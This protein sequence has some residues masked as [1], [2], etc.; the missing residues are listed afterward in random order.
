MAT[1]TRIRLVDDLDNTEADETVM[2][3]LDGVRYEIDLSSA[4]AA[5][6]R[7]AVAGY[8]AA[9]RGGGTVRREA[10]R[11]AAGNGGTDSSA[12]QGGAT[13][14]TTAI[15]AWLKANGYDVSD[16]GRIKSDLLDVYRQRH[17]GADIAEEA[18]A[19]APSG[20]A[21]AAEAPPLDTS[22]EAVLAWH[23]VKGHKVPDNG[24]VNGLMRHRYLKAHKAV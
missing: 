9:V 21:P 8:V 22:D 18:G 1:I 3:S 15:R 20:G 11:R 16:R 7:D 19:N 23:R 14:E 6:L 17:I 24:K 2:F 12:A 10:R 13:S 5:R 4:N